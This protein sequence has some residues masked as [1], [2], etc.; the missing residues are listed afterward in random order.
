TT[1]GL[2]GRGPIQVA[3]DNI[4]LGLAAEKF[5]AKF[6]KK[7]GN[8]KSVIE[9]PGHLGDKEFREWKARWEEFY[10]GEMGDHVTPVL[11]YGMSYKALGIPPEAAQFLQTREFSIT[12]VSRWFNLPPHMLHDLTRSTFSN[13][14]HQDIQMVKY[15]LRPIVKRQENELE[16]KLLLPK[17]RGKLVIRYN[18]D[19][20]LRGDLA[21][22]TAHIKEMVLTGVYNPDE[23]RALLNK[24]PRP[25]GSEYYTP[26][27]I[28]G[29]NNNQSNGDK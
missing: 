14:E 8:L 5:G 26:A 24:N 6:F 22:V 13:I 20:L 9:T 18:M 12:D 28:V 29:K 7:G 4:G 23:G 25:G 19:A 11:E 16:S 2:W 10:T 15:S 21:S 27:N 17:E 3:K 1:N